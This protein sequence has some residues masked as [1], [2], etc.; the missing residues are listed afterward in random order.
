MAD[1]VDKATR[2]RMMS[3]VRGKNTRPEML[4]RKNL[5]ALGFRYRL[6][7]KRLPGKPDIV[8]P[9]YRAVI[10]IH[11]CFW[12]GHNCHLYRQPSSNVTFWKK[13]I[14]ANRQNDQLTSEA[15]TKSGWRLMVIWECALK[16]KTR[17][18]LEVVVRQT[19]EWIRSDTSAYEIGGL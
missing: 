13:K 19:S 14:A 17:L 15:I 16:G 9:R 10:L 2:S 18:P 3:G 5:H 1:V 4:I 12:H 7:D 11:G 8:L 6:H